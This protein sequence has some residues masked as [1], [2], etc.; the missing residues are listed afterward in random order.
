MPKFNGEGPYYCKNCDGGRGIHQATDMACPHNGED[1]TGLDPQI[2]MDT[3][4]E[5]QDWPDK[6]ELAGQ[7]FETLEGRTLF[8]DYFLAAL[9][10]VS[11]IFRSDGLNQS[12]V[13]EFFPDV[14]ITCAFDVANAAMKKREEYFAGKVDENE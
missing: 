13:E 10:G 6:E 1:Q 12:E 7:K 5:P 3:K 8:D 4:F 11:A 14:V 2:Y 9:A